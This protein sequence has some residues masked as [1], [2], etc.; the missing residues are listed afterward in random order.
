MALSRKFE[1]EKANPYLLDTLG[2]AHH[3][4]GHG[5]DAVRVL[6]QATAMAPDHP[7]L[8]YHLGAAYVKVGRETDA[9]THL[10]KAVTSG[11]SFD[12]LNDAKTLLGEV[13]G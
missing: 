10:K 12:G 2:W 7:I 11:T 3:K 13:A 9:V 6:Q 5:A 1:S 8:N 4:L